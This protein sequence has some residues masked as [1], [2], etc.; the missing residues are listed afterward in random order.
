[1]ISET[2]NASRFDAGGLGLVRRQEPA[3]ERGVEEV[4]VAV[5]VH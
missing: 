3:L 1:M 2:L 4:G 5:A